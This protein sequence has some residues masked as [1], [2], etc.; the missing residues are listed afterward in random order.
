MSS[1][2]GIRLGTFSLE[3]PCRATIRLLIVSMFAMSAPAFAQMTGSV[4]GNATSPSAEIPPG[5]CM[6]IG[7]TASG[8]VVFPLTCKAF[9]E[10]RRGPIDEPKF[11]APFGKQEAP[12]AVSA[13]AI[14]V[15]VKP[16][17]QPV[18]PVSSPTL[19]AD[20]DRGKRDRHAKRH[21]HSRQPPPTA[22]TPR[23]SKSRTHQ[24]AS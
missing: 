22:D 1:R 21:K 9:L 5:G 15:P 16:E 4:G 6:P 8:E 24:R 23:Q 19:S 3:G 12:P 17:V 7:V 11:P 13:T 20:D 10:R 18:A 2:S 14:P